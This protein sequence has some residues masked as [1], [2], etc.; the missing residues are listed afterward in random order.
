[1]SEVKKDFRIQKMIDEYIHLQQTTEDK[2]MRPTVCDLCKNYSKPAKSFCKECNEILCTDCQTAHASSSLTKDH[3]L[4]RF[5]R[6][7]EEKQIEIKKEMKKLQDTNFDIQKDVSS[8]K[9]LLRKIEESEDM[10]I[11]EIN[12]H[13]FAI[14]DTVDQHHDELINEVKSINERFKDTLKGA[15][16]LFEKCKKKLEDKV[17]Y[18]SDVCQS[19]NYSLMVQTLSNLSQQIEK[20]LQKIHAKLPQVSP[21]V[22][23]A[24]TVMTGEKFDPKKSTTIKVNP[25]TSKHAQEKTSQATVCGKFSD[26]VKQY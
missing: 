12:H 13:R 3:K 6:L 15:E 23:V 20:D 1:M 16:S 11:Q 5:Q 8:A 21:E 7:C 18:L 17:S 26:K 9:N 22:F 2:D 24:I 19:H 10:I 25:S 4:V 14:K